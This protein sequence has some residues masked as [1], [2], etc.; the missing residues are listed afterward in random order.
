MDRRQEAF[1]ELDH[2]MKLQ[3]ALMR[4]AG[5]DVA[6]LRRLG[7]FGSDLLSTPPERDAMADDPTQT[8]VV[9]HRAPAIGHDAA[10]NASSAIIRMSPRAGNSS[11]SRPPFASTSASRRRDLF[12]AVGGCDGRQSALG[13]RWFAISPTDCFQAPGHGFFTDKLPFNF[14]LLPWIARACR[15]PASCMWQRDPM[16]TCF[17]NLKQLFS[18]HYAACYSQHDMGEYYLAYHELMRD[19]DRLLPDASCSEIRNTRGRS[20]K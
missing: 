8:P 15:R 5:E 17:S 18:R 19:W 3:R 20:R 14:M 4:Y 2:G 9:H 10:S 16:D 11:A 1:T 13:R 7:G 12:R 6:L